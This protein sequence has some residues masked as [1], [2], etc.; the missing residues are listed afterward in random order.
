MDVKKKVV[1]IASAIGCY[2][3]E[4]EALLLMAQQKRLAEIPRATYSPYAMAGRMA[5]MNARWTWQMRL[6]K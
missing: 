4:E 6:V 2:I 3:Q 1:A 5:A